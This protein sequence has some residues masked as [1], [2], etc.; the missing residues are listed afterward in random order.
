ML[1]LLAQALSYFWRRAGSAE[2]EEERWAAC[3]RSPWAPWS[4]CGACARL[5]GPEGVG[6]FCRR[7]SGDQSPEGK[8]G[9]EGSLLS[10]ERTAEFLVVLCCCIS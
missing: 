10:T 7:L 5:R 2:G 1:G 6:G 4:A 8:A 3:G 9:K